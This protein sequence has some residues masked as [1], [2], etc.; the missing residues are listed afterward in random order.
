MI[1]YGGGAVT[2]VAM[3]TKPCR[4][5]PSIHLGVFFASYSSSFPSPAITLWR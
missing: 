1:T 4:R 3:G 2:V 5:Y